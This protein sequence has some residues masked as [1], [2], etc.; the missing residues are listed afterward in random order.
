MFFTSPK[1][2]NFLE[3]SESVVL[4]AYPDVG[5]VITIGPGLTEL[6]PAFRKR[7]RS[8]H[9][10]RPLR[11]G[12]KITLGDARRYMRDV[13]AEEFE[14]AARTVQ[15][16]EQHVMDGVVSVLWNCGTGAAKWKWA[17][18]IKQAAA[19]AVESSPYVAHIEAG[20]KL[21]LTTA[22]TSAGRVW[23][24][25][26]LRRARE[27]N[28]IRTGSYTSGSAAFS[29]SKA[30]IQAYQSDLAKLGYYK[31]II[32]GKPG[33][34]TKGAVLNFQ[35]A[36]GLLPDGKVGPA[37]RAALKR[38]VAAKG[39]NTTALG[40]GASSAGGAGLGFNVDGPTMLLIAGGAILVLI[41]AFAIW[42]NRGRI[43]GKRTL[44]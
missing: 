42:N 14:P 41:V 26:K 39:Q 40:A 44:A 15:P 22:I 4:V 43:L 27:A 8:E 37:T 9:G 31:G 18:Q 38:A 7:W 36:T 30:D 17:L 28:L 21:L 20:A 34:L 35:R 33:A 13:L 1:G 29:T 3:D 2:I 16:K 19:H 25:L 6:S 5:G 23:N 32:D 24:G 10:G 12:D 11:K